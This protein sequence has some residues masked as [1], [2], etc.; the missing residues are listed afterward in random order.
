[1]TLSGLTVFK[2]AGVNHFPTPPLF[3]DFF[4]LAYLVWSD[5]QASATRAA[6]QRCAPRSVRF[7][8]SRVRFVHNAITFIVPRVHTY[9]SRINDW[10]RLSSC[11]S[12]SAIFPA[13]AARLLL[14]KR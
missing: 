5:N 8:Y 2:T 13:V 14:G 11:H 12:S 6:R 10:Q 9:P 3:S 7:V 4:I 1:E